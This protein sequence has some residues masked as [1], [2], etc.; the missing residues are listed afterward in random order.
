MAMVMRGEV[1]LPADRPTVWAKLN[2]PV[3]LKN[4]VGLIE[5]MQRSGDDSYDFVVRVKLGPLGVAFRG[6]IVL[7]HVDPL[8]GYRINAE[9]EGGIAG[10][11]GGFADVALSDRG[12]GTLLVYAVQ[13]DLGGRLAAMGARAMDGVAQKAADRFFAGFARECLK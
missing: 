4:C 1:V 9:G 5:S 3:A 8:V 7:S 12:E 10:H 6:K 2:D 13:V 11:A